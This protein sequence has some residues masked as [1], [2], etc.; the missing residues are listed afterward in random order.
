MDDKHGQAALLHQMAQCSGNLDR[1]DRPHRVRKV[2]AKGG[3]RARGP[4]QETR[5]RAKRTMPLS[6]YLA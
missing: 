3:E 2:L 4:R 5:L 1:R 6:Q